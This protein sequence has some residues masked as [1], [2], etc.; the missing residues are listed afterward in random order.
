MVDAAIEAISEGRIEAA[1]VDE[2]TVPRPFPQIVV[3]QGL[4]RQSKID[5]ALQ[6]L[7]EL[8]VDRVV[9]FS[10]S[11][12]LPRWD[13]AKKVNIRR[14]WERI[15]YEASKQSRRPWLPQ[16][17]G[18]IPLGEALEESQRQ[19]LCLVADPFAEIALRTAL[20]AG[21]PGSAA[22]VVGPEGGL[23]QSEVGEFSSVGATPVS[24]G[25]QI[26][27]TETAAIVIAAVLMFHFG[28][29]G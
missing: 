12:S 20:P 16:V 13:E 10:V 18:P 7:A 29:L 1:I 14:R 26:L 24:L 5:L 4:A 27:R 17:D 2:E 15:C 28:R 9:I 19:D 8:G 22:V 25:R 23:E 21:N 3:F 11:R 6:K